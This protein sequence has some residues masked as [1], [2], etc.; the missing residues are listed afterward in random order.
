MAQ[1]QRLVLICPSE[2]SSTSRPATM[3]QRKLGRGMS[4]NSRRLLKLGH[5]VEIWTVNCDDQLAIARRE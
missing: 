1:K 5:E 3:L 2:L 4:M